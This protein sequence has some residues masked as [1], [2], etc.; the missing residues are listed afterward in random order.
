MVD[1]TAATADFAL[2]ETDI[3]AA[4]ALVLGV[5]VL[6]FGIRKVYILFTRT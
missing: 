3:L 2:R 1:L 6:M 4:T 5:T